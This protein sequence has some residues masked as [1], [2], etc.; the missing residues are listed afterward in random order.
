MVGTTWSP[1]KGQAVISMKAP[2]TGLT[3][4][5]IVRTSGGDVKA[6]KNLHLHWILEGVR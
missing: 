1:S 3:E 4:R 2:R 5:D 6:V